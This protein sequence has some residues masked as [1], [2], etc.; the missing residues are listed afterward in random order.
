MKLLG[1]ATILAAAV[2]AL[3]VRPATASVFNELEGNDSK[4]TANLATGMLAGDSIVGLSTSGSGA[5]LDYF[6]VQTGALPA[7]IYRHRL[8]LTTTGTAGHTG[9]IRGLSQS[10]GVI[11]TTDATVQTSST[12]TTP[13]RFNQWYGFGS[14]EELYYRVSGGAS[15]TANYVATLSTDVIA[16]LDLGTID[17][18]SNAGGNLTLTSVGQTGGSQVDTDMFVLDSNFQGIPGYLNDDTFASP[19]AGSTLTRLY[20][21]GVYYVAISNWNTATNLASP[22]D[23]DYRAGTVLDF[24]NGIAN[25]STTGNLNVSFNISGGMGGDVFAGLTKAG[26]FDVAFAKFTV[27]PEPATLSL[28]GIGVLAVLR[29]RRA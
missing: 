11:G 24:A 15:T 18:G 8:T 17:V 10:G 4:L 13:A 12:L 19:S 23:D 29:R 21:P 28:L 6:R 9:T 27:I 7:G 22:A 2:A 1:K 14:N 5:G 26:A 16:P 3:C 25:N 20:T